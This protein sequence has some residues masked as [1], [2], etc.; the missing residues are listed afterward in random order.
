MEDY[1]QLVFA[2]GVWL[3]GLGVWASAM[4]RVSILLD[5][6]PLVGFVL[7]FLAAPIG[8]CAIAVVLLWLWGKLANR[9]AQREAHHTFETL[10]GEDNWLAITRSGVLFLLSAVVMAILF[11][12]VREALGL[13]GALPQMLQPVVGIVGGYALAVVLLKVSKAWTRI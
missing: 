12:A 8:G 13:Y 3:V 9:L 4:V 10:Q 2:T 11:L 1:R 6:H 5:L 7:S